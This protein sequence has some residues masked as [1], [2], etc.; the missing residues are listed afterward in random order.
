MRLEGLPETVEVGLFVS[1][2]P[3]I[4]VTRQSG[5]TSSGEQATNG[6]ATFDQVSIDAE[7]PLPPQPWRSDDIGPAGP[8]KVA[9]NPSLTESGGR[10][11]LAGTGEIGPRPPVDDVVQ[12]SLFGVL[13]GLMAIVAVG[14]LFVTS[15]YRRGMIRTTLAASRGRGRMLAAKAIVLGL[16]TFA[17]GIVSTVA[18]FLLTQPL[19]RAGGYR[20]PAF[21]QSRCSTDRCCAPCSRHRP[22]SRPSRC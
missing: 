2:P 21:P 19:L 8:R 6:N 16:A 11:T 10:F 20:P 4:V 5:T 15:E 1:S 13:V 7:R 18:A 3:K 9:T 12:M 17:V 14:V 22:S